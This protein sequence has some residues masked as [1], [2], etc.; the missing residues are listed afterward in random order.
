MLDV[1]DMWSD[2]FLVFIPSLAKRMTR[3]LFLPMYIMLHEACISST[4]IVGITPG[5]VNW[6][7]KCAN[8]NPTSLDKSFSLAY[9][10]NNPK[11]KAIKDAE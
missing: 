4:H 2:E 10:K 5:F 6:G 1:R 8:R 9:S 11:K 3:I 7:V